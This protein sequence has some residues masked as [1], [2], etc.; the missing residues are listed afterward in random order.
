MF[1]PM[2]IVLDMEEY[3]MGKNQ[4]MHLLVKVDSTIELYK[5]K[6]VLYQNTDALVHLNLRVNIK[7]KKDSTILNVNQPLINAIILQHLL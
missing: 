7:I 3:S 5:I 6:R 2:G 1:A 4:I